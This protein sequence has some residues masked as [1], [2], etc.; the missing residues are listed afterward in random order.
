MSRD[1]TGDVTRAADTP[2]IAEAIAAH[3]LNPPPRTT[4]APPSAAEAEIAGIYRA[5]R[6]ADSNGLQWLLDLISQRV[7]RVDA[8]G[9]LESG[10][11][12][13]AVRERRSVPRVGENLYQQPVSGERIA[14]VERGADS[15]MAE[16][17]LQFPRLPRYLDVRWIAPALVASVIVALLT[18]LAWPFAAVWR[19]WR[20]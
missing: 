9:N 12:G 13:L 6:R 10:L 17:A 19:R 11:G 15:Y 7:V 16:P 2:D 18:L 20:P 5:S 1:G 14:F 4:P 8:G 3:F